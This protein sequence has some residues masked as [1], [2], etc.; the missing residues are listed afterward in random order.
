MKKQLVKSLGLVLLGSG[1]LMGCET[2]HRSVVVTPTGQVIVPN[3]P[4]PPRTEVMGTPP[5]DSYAW[6][7]GY[8]TY[9]NSHWL[10]V[11]GHWQAPPQPGETWV[12]GYWHRTV[13]GWVWTPGHWEP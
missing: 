3:Q 5:V 7:P 6:V 9:E 13:G 12:P 2:T 1:L 11:S 8:W 10:W 4:P